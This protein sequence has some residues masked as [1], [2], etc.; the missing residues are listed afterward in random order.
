MTYKTNGLTVSR[1]KALL[2]YNPK[3]GKF[4]WLV[5]RGSV[6]AGKYTGYVRADGYTIIVVDKHQYFAHSFAK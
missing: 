1:L 6:K 3:T 2:D 4:K 5:S